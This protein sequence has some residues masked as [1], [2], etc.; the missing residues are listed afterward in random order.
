[1][2]NQHRQIKG[3]KEL[4]QKTIDAM[5]VVKAKGEEIKNMISDL[6]TQGV[7]FD[8]RWKAMAITTLQNGFMQLTRSITKPDFF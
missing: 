8:P 5:N 3:Y 6:E 1:M 2:E 4:D 7:D